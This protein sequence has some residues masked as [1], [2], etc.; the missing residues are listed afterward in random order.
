MCLLVPQGGLECSIAESV[1]TICRCSGVRVDVSLGGQSLER[2][3][4]GLSDL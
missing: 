2:H 3:K 1:V 4:A